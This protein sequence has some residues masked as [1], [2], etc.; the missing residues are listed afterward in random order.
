VLLFV[1]FVLI[2]IASR[3]RRRIGPLDES[4]VHFTVLPT[5]CDLNLHLNGGRFISFT[6]IARVELLARMRILTKMIRIGW[7]P[8]MGG[9]LVRY[10]KE[11]LPFERFT[12]RTR[13]VG[14]DERWFYIEH[15]VEK[16][17]EFCAIA[18]ARTV[19]RRKGG[20]VPAGE[21]FAL[22]G[23]TAIASPDLP[24][25]VALWRDAENAR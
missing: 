17:G 18:H 4:V 12:V 3:F 7:R 24:T 6:D 1:R 11:I 2:V 14:W 13:V 5:D 10:R 15:V 20:N 22:A 8:I 21:L 9:V 19:I 23:E 16:N 25:V